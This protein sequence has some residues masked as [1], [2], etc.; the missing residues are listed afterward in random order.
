MKTEEP[1]NKQS[2]K[3]GRG[4]GLICY[5]IWL[6]RGNEGETGIQGRKPPCVSAPHT[7]TRTPPSCFPPG[8]TSW[9]TCSLSHPLERQSSPFSSSATP[10]S[11]R[12]SCGSPP[13]DKII[14]TVWGKW[15]QCKKLFF[16][17]KN[18]KKKQVRSVGGVSFTVMTARSPQCHCLGKE[19]KKK[20]KGQPKPTGYQV[21]KASLGWEATLLKQF[22]FNLRILI[23]S[24]TRVRFLTSVSLSFSVCKIGTIMFHWLVISVFS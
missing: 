15:D 14:Y 2:K 6:S 3:E 16:V 17:E 20:K 24:I 13:G 19:L 21:N 23:N 12:G 1:K 11:E 5:A 10:L 18:G 22:Y 4:G 9:L 7:H 8:R